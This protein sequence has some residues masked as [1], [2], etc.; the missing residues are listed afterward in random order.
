MR[1]SIITLNR[2]LQYDWYRSCHLL[3]VICPIS[4]KKVT[5]HGYEIHCS[6]ESKTLHGHFSCIS[7]SSQTGVIGTTFDMKHIYKDDDRKDCFD[8]ATGEELGIINCFFSC[9]FQTKQ[10]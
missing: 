5:L 2:S 6:V 10:R 3:L 8:T 9:G 4:W 7:C 1:N